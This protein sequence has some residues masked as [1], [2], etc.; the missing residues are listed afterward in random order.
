MIQTDSENNQC[1]RKKRKNSGQRERTKMQCPMG[2]L[3]FTTSGHRADSKY[4][5]QVKEVCCLYLIV[6]T[7]FL[8]IPLRVVR[9]TICVVLLVTLSPL[10]VEFNER[11]ISDYHAPISYAFAVL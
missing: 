6:L 4:N 9:F 10:L 8:S 11:P 3:W 2:T 7:Q 5:S 1:E